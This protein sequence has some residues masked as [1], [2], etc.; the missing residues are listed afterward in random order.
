MSTSQPDILEV[1]VGKSYGPRDPTWLMLP[2]A[3]GR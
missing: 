3:G 1:V 2:D